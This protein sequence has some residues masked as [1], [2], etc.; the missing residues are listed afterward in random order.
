MKKIIITDIDECVLQWRKTFVE[1]IEKNG[2]PTKG[3][4]SQ[5]YDICDLVD[6]DRDSL[7]QILY[8][9]HTSTMFE[10]LNVGYSADVYIPLLHDMG[11]EFIAL[12][13]CGSVDEIKNRRIS[14]IKSIFG[15]IFKDIICINHT[16][17]KLDYLKK[18]PNESI[19]VEDRIDNCEFGLEVGHRCFLIHHPYNDNPISKEVTRVTSW[20]DIYN[21]LIK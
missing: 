10:N 16:D 15:D 13:A 7:E 11:Y 12:T 21:S 19:W 14:N 1:Y 17:S 6:A 2:I 18:L 8:E 9:F 5:Y 20:E 4:I 3:E